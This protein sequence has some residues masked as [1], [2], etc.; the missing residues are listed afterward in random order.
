ME[1][2]TKRRINARYRYCVKY[3]ITS[4]PNCIFSTQS[5][6]F[7]YEYNQTMIYY[8]A[9]AIAKLIK[10]TYELKDNT[11]YQIIIQNMMAVINQYLGDKLTYQGIHILHHI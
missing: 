10:L 11:T 7:G 3:A 5:Y 6:R 8:Q 9:D 2:I 1:N 4:L